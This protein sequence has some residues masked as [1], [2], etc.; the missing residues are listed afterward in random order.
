MQVRDAV[1]LGV[2]VMGCAA[3]AHSVPP[4]P[5]P[6]RSLTVSPSA[7]VSAPSTPAVPV[8]PPGAPTSTGVGIAARGG[9]PPAL[10]SDATSVG[11]AFAVTSFAYDTAIDVSP[12]DAQRRSAEYATPAYA[13]QLL[14]PL[15]NPSNQRFNDLTTHHGYTTVAL[16]ENHDDG[17]PP[18]TPGTAMRSWTATSTGHGDGGW[19]APMGDVLLFVSMARSPSGPWQVASLQIPQAN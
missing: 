19:T 3:C 18:D 15:A 12:F 1:V 6:P 2:V 11:S 14:Q 8:S 5:A 7:A 9:P 4:A 16:T 13:A 10:A 17:R